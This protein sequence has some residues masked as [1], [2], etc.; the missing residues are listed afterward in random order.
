MVRFNINPVGKEY[1]KKLL[2]I[3]IAIIIVSYI[4]LPLILITLSAFA[5]KEDYYNRRKLIPT[6]FT[7]KQI[8]DL[9]FALGAWKCMINSIIV[10]L[11]TIGL[12]FLLGLPAGYALSR[13]IFPGKEA[14]TLIII[15]TRMFPIAIM[16][17]PL[18][19]LYIKIGLSDTLFGVALVHTAM[20][21]PFVILITSS[22]FRSIPVVFEEAAMVFGLSR[23]E[24]FLHVTL[25]LALPGLAAA[26]MFTFVISWNEVFAASVLTLVNRTLPAFILTTVGAAP[27]PYKFAAGF[28]MALP[29]M[30]FI[31][32]ARKYLVS[33]WG[34]SI[35]G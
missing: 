11:M 28:I 34:I 25:P 13:F 17:V 33:M 16:G 27:D 30:I 29:A 5:T 31:L 22:I 21:L 19:T 4:L 3:L 23:F 32:V 14:L 2:T 9:L 6:H 26:A 24:A 20:A 10:A 35:R 7:L 8:H 1:I 15:A 18:A 12:S